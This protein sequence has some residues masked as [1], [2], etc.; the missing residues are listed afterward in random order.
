MAA[1][2]FSRDAANRRHRERRLI[3]LGRRRAEMTKIRRLAFRA[4]DVLSREIKH[5]GI[6]GGVP[7]R[8]TMPCIDAAAARWRDRC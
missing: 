1:D 4:L 5:I 7:A 6:R 8:R 2:H 3:R